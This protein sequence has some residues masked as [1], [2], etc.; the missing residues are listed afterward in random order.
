MRRTRFLVTLGTIVASVAAM[1][2]SPSVGGQ[3]AADP[4]TLYW[5][6]PAT[7]NATVVERFGRRAVGDET[8]ERIRVEGAVYPEERAGLVPL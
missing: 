4:L 7:D 1:L 6:G 3:E 2:W 5:S 8:Y